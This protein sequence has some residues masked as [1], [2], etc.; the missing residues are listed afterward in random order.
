MR[1]TIAILLGF[2]VLFGTS[3]WVSS[4]INHTAEIIQVQLQQAELHL[5]SNQWE[6]AASAYNQA[7]VNWSKVRKWWAVF[8]NHNTLDNMEICY[9]R[10]QQFILT[11]EKALALA[12]LN[13][14]QIL[15]ENI[16][17]SEALRLNNIL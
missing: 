1:S 12:E 8:L 9:Q 7:Y 15:L 10:L 4:R 13:T 2:I 5:Q 3:F 6:A 11:Q 14:L 17:E 16:P